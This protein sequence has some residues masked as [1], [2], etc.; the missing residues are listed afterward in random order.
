M[1]KLDTIAL[2]ET[3]EGTDLHADVAGLLP[4][5]LAYIIDLLIRMVFLFVIF[6]ISIFFGGLGSGLFLIAFFALEWWYPV[7]FEV[8]RDGQTWG[9]KAYKIKVVNDDLTPVKFGPSLIRNLLRSADFFPLLYSVGI[10]SMVV[11]RRFQRLGDLAAGTIVIYSLPETYDSSALDQ[12]EVVTPLY[13]ISEDLQVAFIN[14]SVN[15]G[16][17]SLDRQEE[18]AEIIRPRLPLN[19]DKASDYARGVG[20]WLLGA[21]D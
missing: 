10:L 2:M 13:P 1:I 11:T 12:V 21:R 14:F 4:R 17:M 15:R 18:I 8:Y 16:Q 3:P 5:A 9:K 20:K 19:V 6:I 7:Y